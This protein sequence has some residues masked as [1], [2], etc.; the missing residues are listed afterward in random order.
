MYVINNIIISSRHEYLSVVGQ[1]G[2]TAVSNHNNMEYIVGP[3]SD[4]NISWGNSYDYAY[5]NGALLSYNLNIGSGK[6]EFP[7]SEIGENVI[8]GWV[9]IKAMAEK[10]GKH[11]KKWVEME[12][13][14][15]I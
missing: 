14:K 10:L 12:K 4:D 6:Y 2:A 11:I 3:V 9:L 1:A 7:S 15:E 5:Q 13:L 8:E